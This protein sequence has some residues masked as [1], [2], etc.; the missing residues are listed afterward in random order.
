MGDISD[1]PEY[2]GY[3]LLCQLVCWSKCAYKSTNDRKDEYF[4]C[5]YPREVKAELHLEKQVL[6]HSHCDANKHTDHD[7]KQARSEDQ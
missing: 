5:L 7:A 1:H 6:L 2:L 3:I 4:D